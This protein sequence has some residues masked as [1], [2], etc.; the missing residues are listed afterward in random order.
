MAARKTQ[1]RK[2]LAPRNVSKSRLEREALYFAIYAAL[3]PDRS[4]R[5]VVEM[6]AGSYAEVSFS[7][8][9]TYS[10]EF[11]WGERL[12]GI[13]IA[14]PDA[15]LFR[16]GIDQ[17]LQASQRHVS[18]GLALQQLALH[19]V[20]AKMPAAGAKLAAEE[21]TGSEIAR[22]FQVGAKT[23]RDAIT[24]QQSVVS[25][26]DMAAQ[27]I[28]EKLPPVIVRLLDHL[29]LSGEAR[30]LAVGFLA[31]EIDAFVVDLYAHFRVEPPQELLRDPEP[32]EGVDI[33]DI[34]AIAT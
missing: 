33:I 14:S 11:N 19:G 8:L 28:H 3:G 34:P 26:A 2:P 6:C 23:E 24:V 18:G 5:K 29:N 21:L 10:R 27:F 9:Q 30:Q 20:R 25:S 32:E 1:Q 17:A 15:A 13:P 12:K 16:R 4:L 22:L 31:A 7:T